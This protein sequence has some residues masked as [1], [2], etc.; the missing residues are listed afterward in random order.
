MLKAHQRRREE[1]GADLH[2]NFQKTKTGKAGGLT[3]GQ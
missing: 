1:Q 2:V 3:A